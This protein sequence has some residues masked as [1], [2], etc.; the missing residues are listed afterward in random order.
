MFEYVRKVL[1]RMLLGV[2]GEEVNE[3]REGSD[4]KKDFC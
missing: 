4:N 1:L 3:K 2:N